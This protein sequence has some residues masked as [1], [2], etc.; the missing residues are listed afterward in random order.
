[1]KQKEASVVKEQQGGGG[2]I[3]YGGGGLG[4]VDYFIWL[5]ARATLPR[6][7]MFNIPPLI[8]FFVLIQRETLIEITEGSE[9]HTL[10]RHDVDS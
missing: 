8:Y 5:A 10:T 6:V 1:M 3:Y 9:I 7:G 4:L 2:C